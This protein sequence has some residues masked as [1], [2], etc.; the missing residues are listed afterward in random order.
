MLCCNILLHQKETTFPP[1]RFNSFCC[2]GRLHQYCNFRHKKFTIQSVKRII[3]YKFQ[4]TAFLS[5]NQSKK[6]IKPQKPI[7]RTHK[8][9]T[10]FN[11]KTGRIYFFYHSGGSLRSQP[12]A[13]PFG[14]G[15]A[16]FAVLR[17]SFLRSASERLRR[18]SNPYRN[19]QFI[20]TQTA[21]YLKSERT[22][23]AGKQKKAPCVYT[24][25]FSYKNRLAVLAEVF[26]S[27]D[28]LTGIRIFVIIPR[29][30]LNLIC[31]VVDF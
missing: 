27:S 23:S 16:C 25:P 1:S 19:Q 3:F 10:H 13:A 21:F 9:A 22:F 12:A 15:F 18:H 31:V 20:A 2:G 4:Y 11:H 30:N 7:F 6:N 29:N 28:H 8:K 24:M 5:I 26:D 17:G 14:S